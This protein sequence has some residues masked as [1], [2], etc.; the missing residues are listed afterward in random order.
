MKRKAAI[1]T[2]VAVVALTAIAPAGAGHV[3]DHKGT[4]SGHVPDH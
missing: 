4:H 2:A 3:S 1:L